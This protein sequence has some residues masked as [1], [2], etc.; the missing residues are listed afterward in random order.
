VRAWRLLSG[1]NSRDVVT[2]VVMT[3]DKECESDYCDDDHEDVDD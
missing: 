2:I 1:Y 3:T